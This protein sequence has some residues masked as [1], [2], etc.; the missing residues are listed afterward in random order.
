M[1]AI[2]QQY[3]AYFLL[4]TAL[5]IGFVI[6][7][8]PTPACVSPAGW[9]LLAIFI[10]TIF[11]I[12]TKAM[13]M[14]V[15]AALSLAVC[16]ATKTL[17]FNEAFAGFSNDVVWLV[18]FAFF[19]AKAFGLSGLG[20]RIAYKIMSYMGKSSLGLG[21]GLVATD[22]LLAPLVPSLAAR[23]GGLIYPILKGL[24]EV[25][26][27]KSHD[28]RMGAYLSMTTYQG[29]AVTSAMFLTAMAGNPLVVQLVRGHGVEISWGTW[30]LAAS[31]PGLLSLALLP[32]FI[33]G[34]CNPTIRK[35][36]HAMEMAKERLEKMGPIRLS[37]WI[38]LGTFLFLIGLW[39]FGAKVG[40]NATVAALFGLSILL[41][42]KILSWK[43]ILEES[44]AW[45]TFFWFAT[46]VTLATSLSKLG[47]GQWFSDCVAGQIQSL[48]WLVGFFLI[49]L[50]YFYTHYF[51]ASNVAHIGAMFAPLFLVALALGTP[52]MVAALSLGFISSL[53][54]GLT[55]YGSG[56]APVLFGLGYASVMEWWKVG[57]LVSLL[58]FSLWIGLGLL[59]WKLLNLW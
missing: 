44:S 57:F 51:F 32:L 1:K 34:L 33:F 58:N 41:V 52:P 3:R 15:I 7:S 42:A 35:T 48:P 50:I 22:L 23:I 56:P 10:A 12:I 4:L 54:G 24:I 16:L 53:F 9:R 26:T 21:Y 49:V 6:W 37:E 30:A 25:F 17:T 55:H 27:G 39:M 46:L 47:V 45:D 38:V 59:W 13:P 40:I 2:Q 14:G 43:D 31:V 20:S 5:L 36:P 8:F 28:P 18:T 29:S 11:S 19:I